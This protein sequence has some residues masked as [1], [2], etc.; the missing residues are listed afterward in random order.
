MASLLVAAIDFGTTYSGYAFSTKHDYASNPTTVSSNT[1]IGGQ[2]LSLK[3]PTCVLF[4]PDRKFH[5][6]GFE[7]EDKYMEL[8]EDNENDEWYFFRRFKMKL[9]QNTVFIIYY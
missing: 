1:W 5:S 6:F 3:A 7:A 4:T 8:S 2:L 9:Y